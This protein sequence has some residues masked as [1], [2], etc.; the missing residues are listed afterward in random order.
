MEKQT[1][2]F[3]W[4]FICGLVLIVI[5]ILMSIFRS[6][7]PADA[8]KVMGTAQEAAAIISANNIANLFLHMGRM[9]CFGV[10][11]VLAIFGLIGLLKKK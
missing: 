5:G 1:K 2:K 6:D 3:L 10:G 7:T 8:L 9:F 11:G 4:L